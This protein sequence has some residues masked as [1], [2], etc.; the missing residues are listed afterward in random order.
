MSLKRTALLSSLVVLFFAAA[1]VDAAPVSSAAPGGHRGGASGSHGGHYGGPSGH[2]GGHYGG[3]YYGHSWRPYWGWGLA[4]GLPLAW[5]WYDPWWWG[6]AYYPSYAYGPVYRGY[7]YACEE[8][9][10]C[11]GNRAVPAD[12]SAPTTQVPPPAAG[13]GGG[14][15]ERPL[16]LNYCE[17]AKAYFPAV[18][19]C[20]EGW[21]MTRPRFN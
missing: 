8:D 12:P 16:H 2:Y 9:Q 19:S 1:G 14:P 4:L 5:G 10:D 20:P 11:W 17:S 15:T 13:A 3:R 21:R 7:P 18:P 6:P